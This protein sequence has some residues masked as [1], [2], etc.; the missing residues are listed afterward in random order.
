MVDTKRAAL[1]YRLD[2]SRNYRIRAKVPVARWES[3][4]S[5]KPQTKVS[6]REKSMNFAMSLPMVVMIAPSFVPLL[7]CSY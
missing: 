5:K 4:R 6:S 1:L 2:Y 7:A 3:T